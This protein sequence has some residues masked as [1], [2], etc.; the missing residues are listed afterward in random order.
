MVGRAAVGRAAKE[1]A[2]EVSS[3][4]QERID[5]KRLLYHSGDVDAHETGGGAAWR[6]E[7][8]LAKLNRNTPLARAVGMCDRECGVQVGPDIQH[9]PYLLCATLQRYVF[10]LWIL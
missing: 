6:A 9:K 5:R 8:V 7:S 4:R 3:N 10:D 2:S 1:M